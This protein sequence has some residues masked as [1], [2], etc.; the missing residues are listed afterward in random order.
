MLCLLLVFHIITCLIVNINKWDFQNQHNIKITATGQKNTEA[1]GSEVWLYE[2]KVDG[3]NKTL[4]NIDSLNPEAWEI[5][6]SYLVSYKEQPAS[7]EFT[8][9]GSSDIELLVSNHP[10]SGF[11]NIE[12][13]GQSQEFDLF[14][15]KDDAKKISVK[16]LNNGYI[17]LFNYTIF[18]FYSYLLMCSLL[19]SITDEEIKNIDLKK[20]SFSIVSMIFITLLVPALMVYIVDP[21]QF[22]RAS[23]DQIYYAYERYQ[24]PG[25]AKNYEY[26][27]IIIGTS[28][29]ENF[30]PSHVDKM[31]SGKSLK[32]SMAGST[33]KE[34]SM[35][36]KLALNSRETDTV[37]WGL[38]LDALRKDANE[39]QPIT[40]FPKYLFN[41]EKFDDL[42][43]LLNKQFIVDSWRKLRNRNGEHYFTADLDTLYNWN[44]SYKFGEEYVRESY[45]PE[46]IKIE[47]R[48]PAL[49]QNYEE[50]IEEN[51]IPLIEDNP[52]VKFV[53]F[54]SPYSVVQFRH[55]YEI[56]PLII[57]DIKEGKRNIFL[58]LSKYKNVQLYD[59]SANKDITSN[60]SV[61]KDT[62]HYS[63]EINK[64]IIES[65]KKQSYL[66][67]PHNIESTESELFK[68]ILDFDMVRFINLKAN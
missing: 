14:L 18:C 30:I 21:L 52:N 58:K 65:I 23:S 67:T 49:K 27:K 19:L 48:D 28:M 9:L 2:L 26:D 8:F 32:L 33:I 5:R 39:T 25:L 64:L 60:L 16:L 50:N 1:K 54:Y 38:D 10:Y 34:Q 40:T 35:M 53:F 46:S 68:Q 11:V 63:E 31:L 44:K 13:D 4:S 6:D 59:F 51:I 29:T 43:Y 12:I 24:N 61:Y 45:R 7:L 15:N 55:W 56:D 42:N 57:S 62:I 17:G 36:T 3:V 41:S 66:V 20:W 47:R 22:Y 37:I